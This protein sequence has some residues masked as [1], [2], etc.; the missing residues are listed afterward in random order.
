VVLGQPTFLPTIHL[1]LPC[2]TLLKPWYKLR[3]ALKFLTSKQVLAPQ[4]SSSVDFQSLGDDLRSTDYYISSP[5]L[6][7]SIFGTTRPLSNQRPRF[8]SIV[9]PPPCP[10]TSKVVDLTPPV[11]LDD[12]WFQITSRLQDFDKSTSLSHTRVKSRALTSG[13]N[14]CWSFPLRP[15]GWDLFLSSALPLFCWT[16]L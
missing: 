1:Q 7:S 12:E 4:S 14:G 8:T 9:S 5:F 16:L 15:N 3:P 2:I 6:W 10:Q 11:L 13:S